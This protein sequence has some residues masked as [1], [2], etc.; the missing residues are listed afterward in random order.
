MLFIYYHVKL[1]EGKMGRNEKYSFFLFLTIEFPPF[2]PVLYFL[3]KGG[4]DKTVFT[5]A[6]LVYGDYNSQIK[7]QNVFKTLLLSSFIETHKTK[8]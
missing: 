7:S 6:F 3:N 5:L 4:S 2:F 8:R 1:K